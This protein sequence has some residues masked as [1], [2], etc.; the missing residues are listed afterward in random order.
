MIDQRFKEVA[1]EAKEDEKDV[2][3]PIT[4]VPSNLKCSYACFDM[5]FK[6][7]QNI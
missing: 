2:Q 6:K 1:H 4:K 3:E 7:F 5:V